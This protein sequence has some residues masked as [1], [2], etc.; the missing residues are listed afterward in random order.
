MRP[1]LAI[2]HDSFREA[3]ASRTLQVLLGLI[4]VLLAGLAIP[5]LR[6]ERPWELTVA[7]VDDPD[8]LI[9]LLG[10]T[11]AGGLNAA[12]EALRARFTP[13]LQ[14][15]FVAY[16]SA[17]ARDRRDAAVAGLVAEANALL[18][19]PNLYDA[20]AWRDIH[21][22][23][24]GRNLLSKPE[25]QRSPDD[26]KRLNRLLFDGAFHGLVQEADSVRA[27]A[28]YLIDESELSL[29]PELAVS[30]VQSI[31]YWL[32]KWFV[33]SV[34]MLAA[35]VFTASMIPQMFE[36]GTIDLLLSKPVSRS[37]AF[38]AKFVGACAFILLNAA[39]FVLGLWL[40]L[41]LRHA[42]WNARILW[43]IPLFLLAFA[44]YFSISASVGVRWRN[45]IL[46][47]ALTLVAWIATFGLHQVWYWGQRMALDGEQAEVV[48]ANSDGPL[49][50]RKNGVVLHWEGAEWRTVFGD[51]NSDPAVAM[52]RRTG[53]MYPLIGPV[54]LGDAD[55]AQLVAVEHRAVSPMFA[56]PGAIVTGRAGDGWQRRAGPAAPSDTLAVLPPI[57]Q[58]LLLVTRSG[59]Q[60]VRLEAAPDEDQPRI[61]LSPVDVAGMAWQEPLAASVDPSR[62]A[63]AVY[64][65]GR[66]ALLV[67]E[68]ADRFVIRHQVDTGGSGP[69]LVGMGTDR[70]VLA[71][72][73][74]AIEQYSR[75]TL[76]VL[77][78]SIQLPAAPRHV[79]SSHTGPAIWILD[80]ERRLHQLDADGR[81]SAARVRGQGGITAFA[82]ANDGGLLTADRFPR[83]TAYA[84]DGRLISTWERHTGFAW[85]YLWIINPLRL[86][87]PK[88]DE[89]DL[90]VREAV[91]A[92]GAEAQAS[93]ES[94]SRPRE[95]VDL[96][97]PVWTSGVFVT[98][99]LAVTCW[100][101][102]RRD[103]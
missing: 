74:G 53:L 48:L 46:A 79:A 12:Q 17:A 21:L 101:I 33:G 22:N 40:I 87:L 37:G 97:T 51:S 42:H 89:L 72:S 11:R 99:V 27:Y 41:G 59:L 16:R 77:G 44:I 45:P 24:E 84:P 2:I 57:D 15:Q 13:S 102:E 65:R 25:D 52:Q 75:D 18:A 32:L 7:Q 1:Y 61:K 93:V 31:A 96:W 43:A 64:S 103:F 71:R 73:D 30:L 56:S 39:L 67:P 100:S 90:L 50:A 3:L 62:S 20:E 8:G 38:L 86:I 94:L 49:V 66:L 26:C 54:L 58:S 10:R 69:V 4:L 63:I 29:P 81:L 9:A 28:T 47:I 91:G 98:A 14:Q 55:T 95:Y 76:Q 78:A 6:L 68:G 35:I 5:G 80:D 88:P 34:G 23:S 83:V 70:I 60:R 85:G 82:V 92:G 19:G 36:P